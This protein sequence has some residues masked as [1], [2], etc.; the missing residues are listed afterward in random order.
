MSRVIVSGC[1]EPWSQIASVTWPLMQHYADR[2]GVP[3]RS[4]T[5][6]CA[7]QRP[8]SWMKLAY[9]ADA[10][11]EFDEVLWLDA[12]VVISGRCDVNIF[13]EVPPSAM[14]A[15][16]KIGDP[17]HHNLGVW[18][19]RRGMARVMMLAAMR[20]QFIHHP[21]WE[22]A[23][24]N[25]VAAEENVPTHTLGEEWNC[26]SG[27]PADVVPKFRHACGISNRLETVQEWARDPHCAAV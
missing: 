1:N 4:H 3:F 22:Q 25:A 17:P 26:W 6:A 2:I 27:S 14:Q 15:M 11:S 20:D 13:A 10:L 19:V 21:W 7:F 23:A 16:A 18:L 24:I 9:V 5:R 12:D 8:E